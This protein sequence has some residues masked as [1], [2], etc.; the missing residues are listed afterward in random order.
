MKIIGITGKSGSGKTYLA[1]KISKY[2]NNCIILTIDNIC[3]ELMNNP[4]M[5]KVLQG[6]FP[7]EE[8]LIKDGQINLEKI[9]TSKS[10]FSRIYQLIENQLIEQVTNKVNEA[11]AEG[12]DTIVL[13]WWGL[14]KTA[15]MEL[16]DCSVCIES[17]KD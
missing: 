13:E 1:K 15:L 12:I 7:N 6:E 5:I 9:L 8:C 17:K 10:I 3:S 11:K 16:C 14:P 4:A 2:F